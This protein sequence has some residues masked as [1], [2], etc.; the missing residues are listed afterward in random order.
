MAGLG[1]GV[2]ARSTRPVGKCLRGQ[3][4]SVLSY[5]SENGRERSS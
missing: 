1:G 4:R 5:M 3:V 2:A